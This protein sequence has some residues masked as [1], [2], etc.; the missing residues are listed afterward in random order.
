MFAETKKDRVQKLIDLY[1][2]CPKDEDPNLLRPATGGR[3]LFLSLAPH[4][5]VNQHNARLTYLELL[6]VPSLEDIR[7]YCLTRIIPTW[8][9]APGGK[10]Y[11]IQEGRIVKSHIYSPQD[12]KD[13]Y[14]SLLD[15]TKA[16]VESFE[17]NGKWARLMFIARDEKFS[18]DE[19]VEAIFR[20]RGAWQIPTKE[21]I[22]FD[23]DGIITSFD[24]TRPRGPAPDD[25]II[26]SAIH[27]VHGN[28]LVVQ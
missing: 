24:Y 3:D 15:S 22:N 10:F 28:N 6:G 23:D 11:K 4:G 1:V 12:V 14:Q 17:R 13:D 27:H 16:F 7:N 18:Q 21:E 9:P 19:R 26:I 25:H 5:D 2:D 8:T 20:L